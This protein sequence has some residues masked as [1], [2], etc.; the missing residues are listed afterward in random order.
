VIGKS[1]RIQAAAVLL[2]SAVIVGCS[3]QQAV[4]PAPDPSTTL[5]AIPVADPAQIE[6]IRDMKTWRNPYLIVRTD[7]VALL[8]AADNAEIRLKLAELLPALAALPASD[9]PYGRVVAAT[10]IDARTSRAGRRYPSRTGRHRRDPGGA[11][12]AIIMGALGV[13]LCTTIDEMRAACRAERLAGKR[14]GFVPT[15]GALHEGH[16]SLVRAARAATDVVA[17]SIFVNPTQFG[18]NEDFAKYPRS[19]ERDREMLER[20]GVEL[21]FAP[22]VEKSILQARSRG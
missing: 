4:A 9:W 10:V 16:L 21:L 2:F 22:S 17:A 20:E 18:P 3:S 15:L 7:G 6:R 14:L 1:F 13:R 8:D 5:Q 12:I 19:F 11:H